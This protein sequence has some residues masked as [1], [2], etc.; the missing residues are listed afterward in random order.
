MKLALITDAWP[1]QTNGVVTTLRTISEQLRAI[2]H[3][4]ETFT[5][6]QFR[7]W[8]CPS[9]PEIRLALGCGPKLRTRLDAFQP[10]AIHI[11]TEGPLGMAARS[12]C[13]RRGL[14]YTS[15]FHT[16][17][18]EYIHLRTGLPLSL[19]Y[20]FLRWFHGE[21]ERLMTATPTL[22]EEL[23]A[24]GFK[25]PVLWSR[26]VDTELFRPRSKDFLS[27]PRPV[28][29]YAGRVAIEKNIEAFLSLD[30]PG[31][32]Y[33]VGDGPQREELEHKYPEVRFVG[34]KYG[35]DLARYL[36]AADV[37]VFPSR[38][39]TFGLVMLE[40]LASGVPVAAFPVEGPKDVILSDRVGCLDEDLAK[41]VTVALKLDAED[42]RRYA[43]R[44]SWRDCALLF[45][46]YLVPIPKN[47]Q[48]SPAWWQRYS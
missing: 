33:V 18:A 30:L 29:L 42:C 35:E 15:S 6:D 12:Y 21:S 26:G 17:F 23:K 43:L 28:L 25:N 16:R 37:F 47:G 14:P 34:Y 40:A 32:K 22:L 38:T 7:T 46:S 48:R 11:A 8:P 2:G 44:Y 5:P 10:D 36:A 24:R 3:T 39:D 1:P 20:S 27:D 19:G 9:Y 45:E 13:K 4:V 41:A 31:T